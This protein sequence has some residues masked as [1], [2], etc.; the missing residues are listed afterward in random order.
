M[1]IRLAFPPAAAV[2]V[3]TEPRLAKHFSHLGVEVRQIGGPISH[4]GT[5][6]PSL[7]QVEEI[8]RNMRSLIRPLWE[9]V[10]EQI[11]RGFDAA[12]TRERTK[13]A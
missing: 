2:F 5:R 9:I 12:E 13:T 10:H 6:I 1:L 7:M 3:L 4:R 8:I 11:K